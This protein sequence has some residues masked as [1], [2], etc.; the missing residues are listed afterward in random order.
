[1]TELAAGG[2]ALMW[3]VMASIGVIVAFYATE[4]VSIELIS[5]G[6]IAFFLLLFTLFPAPAPDFGPTQILS[7][8]A[9]PALVTIMSLLVIGQGMFQTGAL[10]GPTRKLT[11]SYD[12][13]PRLTL[14]AVFTFMFVI[15]AF[16]NNTPVVVMF[17]PIMAA[18][19]HRMGG[20]PSA[21]MMPLS[22]VAIFAGMTTLIGSSTNLLVSDVLR[23]VRGSGLDFFA[24][25]Q[26]GMVL[27][28]AGIVYLLVAGRFLIPRR[29]TMEGELKGAAGR[30]FIA[31]IEVTSGHP[32]EGKKPVM[33]MFQDLPN[34]TVR[35]VQRGEHAFLPPFDDIALRAGDL[36]IVATTRKNLTELLSSRAEFLRGMMR[37]G[38]FKLEEE[39]GDPLMMSEV[40]IA[41]ASRF[42]GRT[43][44]QVGFRYQTGCIV[45]GV[46]RRSRMIRTRMGEIRLEAGDTLLI[47]GPESAVKSLRANR[48]VLILEWATQDVPDVRRARRAIYVFG[49][50]IAAAATGLLPIVVASVLGATAMVALGCLNGRQAVRSL[51]IRVFMLIGAAF[52]MGES[53]Q[54]TGG[55]GYLAGLVVDLFSPFGTAVLISALFLLVAVM[56]NILSN[57]AT[58]ILFAPIA[59][60]AADLMDAP[61]EVFVLTVV[62]GANCCFATPIAYQTNL[63][64]MGPGHYKFV[65]FLRVGGPLVLVF[66]VVY[67]LAAPIM[68]DL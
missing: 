20:S 43:I 38:D 63:L 30:Q 27:A 66:W 1:L 29:E 55:A 26:F 12:R 61:P 25:T 31:Q 57:S 39:R 18:I 22:F 28:A 11:A 41:P 24:P 48:D 68:F 58:A 13:Y 33:G 3:V 2:G 19:A 47:F 16:I 49:S 60:Q 51:D 8:F 62:F 35:M 15:S 21:L 67:S 32:L 59:I 10:E 44:E 23:Q 17:I 4:R 42:I 53:M 65:D 7:G 14:L 52:A 56:T 34:M 45:L 9:N 36:V 50:V 5:A 6:V 54:A 37:V 46:Q 40:V 64:V